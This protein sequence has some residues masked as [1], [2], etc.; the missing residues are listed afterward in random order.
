MD[1]QIVCELHKMRQFLP[2]R[3][4]EETNAISKAF[5]TMHNE[6]QNLCNKVTDFTAPLNQNDEIHKELRKSV[7]ELKLALSNLNF[8]RG[9]RDPNPIEVEARQKEYEQKLDMFETVLEPTIKLHADAIVSLQGYLKTKAEYHEKC[10]AAIYDLD[11]TAEKVQV[12]DGD[13]E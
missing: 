3:N 8:A 6:H 7:D 2:E 4:R 13:D 5:F 1:Y 11:N 12:A 9:K 10:L